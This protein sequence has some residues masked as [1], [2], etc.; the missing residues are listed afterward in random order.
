M[1]LCL[2]EEPNVISLSLSLSLS[3]CVCVCQTMAQDHGFLHEALLI[4]SFHEEMNL[5]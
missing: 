4:S 5:S 3:L 2:V 1:F